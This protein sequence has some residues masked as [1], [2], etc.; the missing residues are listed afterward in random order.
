MGSSRTW[1]RV[2]GELIWFKG[3]VAVEG[4]ILVFEVGSSVGSISIN[5]NM[6]CSSSLNK[7]PRK[8]NYLCA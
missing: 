3:W 8:R 4:A 5:V 6:F 1:D 2:A 7:L